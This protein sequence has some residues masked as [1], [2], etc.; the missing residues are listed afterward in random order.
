MNK[1]QIAAR[2]E[3]AVAKMAEAKGCTE[4]TA[5]GMFWM[6]IEA[7]LDALQNIAIPTL[8]VAKAA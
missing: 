5:R 3:A 1:K 8:A 6:A 2:M 4:E 7:N